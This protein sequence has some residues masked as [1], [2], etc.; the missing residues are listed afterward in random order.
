M[1]EICTD[2]GNCGVTEFTTGLR[3]KDNKATFVTL[4]PGGC[5]GGCR[6]ANAPEQAAAKPSTK[7][8]GVDRD[9]TYNIRPRRPVLQRAR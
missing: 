3:T 7:K 6:G 1:A 8:I 5:E 2:F 9:L 4:C